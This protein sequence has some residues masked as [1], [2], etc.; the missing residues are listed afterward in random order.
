MWVWRGAKRIGN[1]ANG[2]ENR[3]KGDITLEAWLAIDERL[4]KLS[5]F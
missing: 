1:R 4:I 5:Q 2:I 3:V